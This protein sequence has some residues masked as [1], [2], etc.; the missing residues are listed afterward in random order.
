MAIVDPDNSAYLL[1]GVGTEFVCRFV[2]I[3][4]I[5]Q[6]PSPLS[7]NDLTDIFVKTLFWIRLGSTLQDK[8]DIFVLYKFCFLDRSFSGR[9]NTLIC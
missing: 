4:N 6:P 1:F 7:V 3:Y 9:V 2:R 5:E 8:Q